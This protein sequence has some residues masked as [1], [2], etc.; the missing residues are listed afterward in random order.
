[1]YNTSFLQFLILLLLLFVLFGDFKKFS[2]NFLDVKNFFIKT[3]K[4]DEKL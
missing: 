3:F 4:K 2:T 1:M